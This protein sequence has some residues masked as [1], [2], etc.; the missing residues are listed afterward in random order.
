MSLAVFRRPARRRDDR[1]VHRPSHWRSSFNNEEGYH[2]E[3]PLRNRIVIKW[4]TFE[5]RDDGVDIT[6]KKTRIGRWR[7]AAAAQGRLRHRQGAMQVKLEDQA[8]Y[9]LFDA[10]QN[11]ELRNWL[12]TTTLPRVQRHLRRGLYTMYA[13]ALVL[14]QQK[15]PPPPK[16]ANKTTRAWSLKKIVETAP[17]LIPQHRDAVCGIRRGL[18]LVEELVQNDL[19][20]FPV[21]SRIGDNAVVSE[22]CEEL[23]DEYET[24]IINTLTYKQKPANIKLNPSPVRPK[25]IPVKKHDPYELTSEMLMKIV[26]EVQQE[27]KKEDRKKKDEENAQFKDFDIMHAKAIEGRTWIRTCP[28]RCPTTCSTASTR[29]LARAAPLKAIP[30][31]EMVELVGLEAFVF[32]RFMRMGIRMTAFGSCIGVVLLV[33]RDD[34]ARGRALS[35][36]LYSWTIGNVET[37]VSQLEHLLLERETT[38]DEPT[39][40][41]VDENCAALLAGAAEAIPFYTAVLSQLNAKRTELLKRLYLAEQKIEDEAALVVTTDREALL[42]NDDRLDAHGRRAAKGLRSEK[43]RLGTKGGTGFVTFR[44]LRSAAIARQAQLSPRPFCME[45]A[46]H[47]PEPRNVIWAN[48]T[49]SKTERLVRHNIMSL[50]ACAALNWSMVME[51]CEKVSNVC[52]FWDNNTTNY[53]LSYCYELMQAYAPILLVNLI[54]CI[55]PFI[56]MFIGKYYERFKFTSEVQQTVFRRYLMFELANIWLALVSGTIWTLLELLAEEPVT[57]LEYIALIM[58]QAAVYFVEMI[59]MKLMLVLPFEISRLWPWF[60]IEFVRRSFK[61]RLTD[62]DLTKGA[63]EPPEFRYGFQYPSKL[64]VLTYAFVFAGI[65]PIVYPAFVFFYCAYFVYTRH[66]CLTLTFYLLVS[67]AYYHALASTGLLATLIAWIF[68]QV[69]FGHMNQNL[70]LESAIAPTRPTTRAGDEPT[71][72]AFTTE[73]FRQPALLQGTLEPV[74]PWHDKDEDKAVASPYVGKQATALSR[75]ADPLRRAAN[76]DPTLT[77]ATTTED[78]KE[79]PPDA[80]HDEDLGDNYRGPAV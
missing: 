77:V 57:V 65:A 76:N 67:K 26:A 41:H 4:S 74:L 46:D 22:V 70:A 25:R 53:W 17:D 18:R 78:R 24:E 63:F 45:A 32:I 47:R 58:P 5:K 19:C 50:A 10:I 12:E 6:L 15:P 39:E 64:M 37:V 3:L 54:L 73:Y 72:D 43:P 66:G 36:T 44:S 20:G 48:V 52:I 27:A 33:V 51:L 75:V 28:A 38:G 8:R 71:C 80:E 9:D 40:W 23:L 2:L 11:N 29:A 59:I 35:D 1:P 61:D 7:S 79:P 42:A 31:D 14:L 62:R 55:L 69:G 13:R 60:R 34:A 21:K 16:S 49:S 68:F 30:D 56:L